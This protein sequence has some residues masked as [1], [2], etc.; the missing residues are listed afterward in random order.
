MTTEDYDGPK[1]TYC[2]YLNTFKTLKEKG[3]DCK[4]PYMDLGEV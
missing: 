4:D 1:Y 3:Y 2:T